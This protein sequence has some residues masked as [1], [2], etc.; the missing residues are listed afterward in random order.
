MR[1]SECHS[2]TGFGRSCH[3]ADGF[4]SGCCPMVLLEGMGAISPRWHSR[5]APRWTAYG[6]V[7][8]TCA[9]S[10]S[11]CGAASS[12]TVD[13]IAPTAACRVPGDTE[14]AGPA[15]WPAMERHANGRRRTELGP[16]AR[17]APRLH[18]SDCRRKSEAARHSAAVP[19]HRT[20]Q[21]HWM[22]LRTPCSPAVTRAAS[23]SIHR[24]AP[25]LNRPPHSRRLPDPARRRTAPH[26]TG[27]GPCPRHRR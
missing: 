25:F 20:V 8:P 22:W 15:V 26:E 9:P 27:P 4:A 12:L 24:Q 19:D 13:M 17:Q 18:T 21:P 2:G 1:G 23:R 14:P 3:A 16:G 5:R 11:T 6:R 7:W 10:G